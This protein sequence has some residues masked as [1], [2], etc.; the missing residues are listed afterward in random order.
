MPVFQSRPSAGRGWAAKTKPRGNMKS[1]IAVVGLM[2]LLVGCGGRGPMAGPAAASIA[3]ISGPWEFVAH[4]FQQTGYSTLI[5]TNLQESGGTLNANGA[6]QIVLVGEHPTGG[7][8][9]GGLCPGTGTD[10]LTGS[11]SKANVVSLTLTEGSTAYTFTG[12]LTGT[13][14]AM[15]GTYAFS[16]GDCEDN[17]TFTAQKANALSR[18]LF[19]DA[20]PAERHRC[21]DGHVDG[22]ATQL[23]RDHCLDRGQQR[24][25]YAY[26]RCSGQCVLSSRNSCG[27]KRELLRILRCAREFFILS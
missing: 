3:Q 24:N 11:I 4:S 25:R 7:L 15:S 13:T 26:G 22:N 2:L 27:R 14:T 16:S 23:F 9:F 10:A 21:G 1:S 20:Y 19:W 6:N 17:G 5:E 18:H 12:S 8:Y